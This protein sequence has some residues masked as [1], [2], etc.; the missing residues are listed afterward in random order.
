MLNRTIHLTGVSVLALAST[1][2]APTAT[3]DVREDSPAA[4][5]VVGSSTKYTGS[6]RSAMVARDRK[7]GRT[8]ST[9]D[10]QRP[11]SQRRLPP[12]ESRS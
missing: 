6:S 5:S 10:D 11:T 9:Q 2:C 3:T 8:R 7:A 4:V 12:I 1:S